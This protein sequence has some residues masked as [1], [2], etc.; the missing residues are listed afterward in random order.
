MK[1]VT[2]LQLYLTLGLSILAVLTSLSVRLVQ[3]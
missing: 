2:D 3:I 1:P